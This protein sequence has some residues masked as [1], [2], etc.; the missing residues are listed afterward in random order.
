MKIKSYRNSRC[1]QALT[2][3]LS[4]LSAAPFSVLSDQSTTQSYIIQGASLMDVKIAV[5]AVGGELT[6]ELGIIQAMGGAFDRKATGT[7][8]R[9]RDCNA[10]LPRPL[11]T[12]KRLRPNEKRCRRRQ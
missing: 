5:Q 2:I 1:L 10:C 9:S 3:G 8:C 11:G 6:H 4:L 7:A 12:G